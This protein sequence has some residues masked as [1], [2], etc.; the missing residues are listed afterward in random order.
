VARLAAANHTDFRTIIE[1]LG[2][3]RGSQ[4]PRSGPDL[5]TAVL[6]VNEAA[7]A[8]LL[9]YTGLPADRLVRA[10]PSLEPVR[11]GQPGEPAVR[12]SALR[13][14]AADCPGCLRRRGG[15]HLDVRLFPHKTLCLRHGYW[16]F[17]HGR[18]RRLDL[19]QLPQVAAAQRRLNRAAR[20]RGPAAVMHAYRLADSY[21]RVS[22]RTDF[23][24][25]WYPA[26]VSR[27]EQR[28]RA[29]DP[30]AAPGAAWQLPQWA[31]HPECTA[32]GLLFASPYWA[33]LAVPAPDR[34]HRWFYQRLLTE[35]G[36]DRGRP[37]RSVR[38]FAPLPADIQDQAQWGRLLNSLD[39][40]TPVP[41][42]GSPRPVPFYDLTDEYEKSVQKLG[43]TG[44]RNVPL[45]RGQRRPLSSS[46]P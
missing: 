16:L 12:V 37:P 8:R 11:F 1:L 25:A 27:W 10:I 35:L 39:W 6:T 38:D 36:V 43:V 9:G 32:L 20:R 34:R 41:V 13:E 3:L 46:W 42:T 15:A 19:T 28:A 22:W 40:G 29:G 21:L 2:P 45:G 17:G 23:H 24:P 4:V 26:L 14:P 18:G 33:E 7:F 44:G 31:L 30:S 5:A